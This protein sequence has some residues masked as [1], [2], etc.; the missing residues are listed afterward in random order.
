MYS[1]VEKV[2]HKKVRVDMCVITRPAGWAKT[3]QPAG[4]I[5]LVVIKVHRKQECVKSRDHR[6]QSWNLEINEF[7]YKV[8]LSR[9]MFLWITSDSSSAL[10]LRIQILLFCLFVRVDLAE[11]V[12][13]DEDRVQ[14]HRDDSRANNYKNA[15]HSDMRKRLDNARRIHDSK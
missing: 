3:R 7:G 2:S 13:V 15:N 9:Q 8:Y 11:D 12:F 10:F 1:A 5:T 4:A 14:E 6:I